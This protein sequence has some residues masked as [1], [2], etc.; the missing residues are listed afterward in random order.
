MKAGIKEVARRAGVSPATVTRVLSGHPKVGLEH[1]QLIG[2]F[3]LQGRA[4]EVEVGLADGVYLNLLDHRQVMVTSGRLYI[5][6]Q[7][8][9]IE[10]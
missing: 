9:M 7:P 10:L 8:I 5:Y 6:N 4:A 3:S 2:V 1:R